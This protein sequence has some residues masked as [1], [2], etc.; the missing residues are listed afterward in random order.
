MR[1]DLGSRHREQTSLGEGE[2]RI[3]L[4]AS[5]VGRLSFR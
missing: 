2:D 5:H 1:L 3:F 4:N